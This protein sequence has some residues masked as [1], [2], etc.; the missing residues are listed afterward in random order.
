M[1]IERHHD[2]CLTLLARPH[3]HRG[4]VD[5]A[6]GKYLGNIHKHA[7]AVVRIN[8]NF[9]GVFLRARLCFRL[10]PLGFNQALT[11]FL[12]QIHH[13]DAVRPVDRDTASPCDKS[14]DLV[15]RNRAAALRKTNRQIVDSL[16]NDTA[17]RLPS[18]D[19][20][21]LVSIRRHVIEDRR[22]GYFL[23]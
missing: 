14:D 2:R 19:H 16:D 8:L 1:N 4:N 5:L 18:C 15:A 9:G 13:I 20:R 17:L 11:L 10:L 23:L 6:L 7:D 12:W 22:V 3:I 21:N